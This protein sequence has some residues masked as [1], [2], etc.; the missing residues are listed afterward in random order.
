MRDG[1]GKEARRGALLKLSLLGWGLIQCC[2]GPVV[3]GILQPPDCAGG[4]RASPK[5]ARGTLWCQ[6][7]NL[8]ECMGPTH[9]SIS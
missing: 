9:L 4:S 8:G 1:G 6:E 5:D 3:L 2:S 7:S